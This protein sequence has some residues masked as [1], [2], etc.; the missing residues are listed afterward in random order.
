MKLKQ[1][2][3]ALAAAGLLVAVAGACS[4]P[5]ESGSSDSK[6]AGAD[7]PIKVGVILPMSG[8]LAAAATEYLNVAKNLGTKIPDTSTIDGRPVQVVLRDDAGTAAG[9]A[10]AMRQLL[11]Q[12][13]VD[14]IIGPLYTLE[15]QAALPLSTAAK[16]PQIVFTGCPDCG[17][18]SKYP[19]TFSIESDR[20]SQMPSTIAGIKSAGLTSVAMLES[21]DA[22]G[23]AYADAFTA[24]AQKEGI[25]IVKTVHF[26]PN[27]LDLGTQAAQLKASGANG[28]FTACAVPADVANA[29]KAM[30][31]IS[32]KPYIFGNVSLGQPVAVAA[33][34]PDWLKKWAASGYGKN[35]T[36]P[37]TPEKT[38]A[39]RDMIKSVEGLKSIT[40]T[41][42]GLATA[43]DAFMMAKA[44]I[45]G[46]H[47]TD[48]KTMA[49][50][51]VKNGYN[52]AKANFKFT[53]T[54]HNGMT[55]DVQTLM[56]PGTQVDGI[57]Q[58]FKANG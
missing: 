8:P 26:A 46:T 39:F 3:G 30:K 6:S 48:A 45:E 38:L 11:D 21:D 18:A 28:V 16:V 35:A 9:T 43:Y 10:T 58:Q 5:A 34:D 1:R 54:Q 13:K 25:K 22:T 52:G 15:A 57:P 32:Y 36:S 55:A 24:E 14:F 37:G 31:E 47:S 7:T 20:P 2:L 51:L 33:G 44:A 29:L 23:Q 53:E 17:D 42:N 4:S 40:T 27:T 19:Y 41:V 12:D 50:W 49:D 56:Q